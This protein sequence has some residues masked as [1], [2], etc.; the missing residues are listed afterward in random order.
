MRRA[1]RA[2]IVRAGDIAPNLYLHAYLHTAA[3]YD[4][5]CNVS[6]FLLFPLKRIANS[7]MVSFKSILFELYEIYRV[8]SLCSISVL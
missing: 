6:K 5:N 2:R 1:G 4:Q 3:E 7:F 8:S